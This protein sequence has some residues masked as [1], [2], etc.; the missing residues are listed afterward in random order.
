M[1]KSII[2]C[3]S[4]FVSSCSSFNLSTVLDITSLNPYEKQDDAFSIQNIWSIDI[5]NKR[6]YKTGVLQP[7]F[8][9]NNAYTIDSQGFVSAI[10]LLDGNVL[11]TASLDMEVSSGLSIH[12]KKIFF[13]TNDGMFYG[14]DIE[15]LVNS[16]SFIDTLDFIDFLDNTALVPIMSTQLKSEASSPAIGIDDLIF[17]KLDDGDTTAINIEDNNLEWNYKG[18]NVPL[19]IKGSGAIGHQYNNIYVPRDDG[20]I[21]SLVASSGKLNWLASISPRS[22]RNEL[23]SLRDVEI[24]PVI[25]DGVL[26]IG[27]YQGNLISIDILNGNIIWSR[28]MSVMSHFSVDDSS[29]Y[30][31]DDAGYI[32][33]IDRY[34]GDIQW[35]QKIPNNTQSTQT[36]IMNNYI[37]SL[38]VE[39]HVIVIDKI[40]GKLLVFERVLNDIDV[41]ING[42]LQDKTL[43]IVSKNGRLNAIKIN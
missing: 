8:M 34:N 9:N 3:L 18:R 22:G 39:G 27:S 35:K 7:V 24:S 32:Y 26:F 1:K 40:D 20:N 37:L 41:Q 25:S 36:F 4:F 10:N 15:T 13:G 31:S 17:I 21:I 38:S 29:L 2:L 42:L 30:I 12:N 19:S 28:P 5:G 14:Y 11:W 23:E 6:D 16:Y 33:S 43:Y